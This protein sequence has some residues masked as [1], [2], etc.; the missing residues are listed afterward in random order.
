MQPRG[1]YHLLSTNNLQFR[2]G[3]DFRVTPQQRL[4]L[5]LDIFN[6]FNAD[7]PLVVQNNSSQTGV[8][9]G[10]T[11]A[12]FTPRRAQVGFRYEF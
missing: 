11:L 2:V 3:K 6:I 12:V 9:F 5:F 1:D 7:S 10:Q 4:R 8:P